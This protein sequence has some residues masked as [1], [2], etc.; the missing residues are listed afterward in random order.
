MGNESL[1]IS[2]LP[3]RAHRRLAPYRHGEAL[4]GPGSLLFP[5]YTTRKLFIYDAFLLQFIKDSVKI[6]IYCGFKK[7]SQ[8]IKVFAAT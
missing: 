2:F 8:I 6:N 3:L 4:V 1:S 5:P 7:S